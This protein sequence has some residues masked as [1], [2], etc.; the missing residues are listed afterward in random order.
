MKSGL[1]NV[2]CVPLQPDSNSLGGVRL[3]LDQVAYWTER[4]KDAPALTLPS[5]RPRPVE[6]SD[7]GSVYRFDVH[8]GVA[9]RL[10]RLAAGEGATLFE[11]VLSAYLV[12]LYRYTGQTDLLVG[13]ELQQA[14]GPLVNAMIVRTDL[15]GDPTFREL[16]RRVCRVTADAQA[17]G[18]PDVVSAGGPDRGAF[19]AALYV[20]DGGERPRLCAGTVTCDIAL[21]VAAGPSWPGGWA[22]ELAYSTDLFDEP[23]MARMAGHL[24]RI[25]GRAGATPDVRIG[26]IDLLR[27]DERRQVLLDWND[28]QQ[29]RHDTRCMH[30]LFEQQ[31]ARTPDAIAVVFG[32]ERITYRELNVRANQLAWELRRQGVVR[33]ALVGVLMERSADMVAALFAVLKAGG[34]Y[35][36][37]DPAYPAERLRIVLDDCRPWGVVTEAGAGHRLSSYDGH[38]V[39]PRS[40]WAADTALDG[41][42]PGGVTAGDL[43]YLIYTSGSTGKPKGVMIEHRSAVELIAWAQDVFDRQALSCVL[44]STSLCFD[45]SVFEVFVPLSCGGSVLVVQNVL[46]WSESGLAGG[47]TLINTVPSALRELL[48][49][50]RLPSGVRI[51]NVAGEALAAVLVEETFAGADG[52]VAMFNLYGPSEDTTYST[53]ASVE[54]GRLPLIGRPISNTRGY[55]VDTCGMPVPMGVPGEIWIGGAGLARG[56]WDRQA[57]TAERF[58]PDGL[59][60]ASGARLYRT[61]DLGRWTADG[62]MEFLGRLDHQVKIRGHRI[63]LGEVEAALRR[64]EWVE[65]AVVVVREEASGDKRLAAYVVFKAGTEDGAAP[66]LRAYLTE[67]L[68]GYMV[69]SFIVPLAAMP[70]TPNGKVDRRQLP[71]P[72]PMEM[73]R[74]DVALQTPAE[75]LLAGIWQDVLG[76]ARVGAEDDFFELGGHSLLAMRLVS[77]VRDVFGVELPL[78]RLFDEP[79]LHDMARA[80]AE[81]QPVAACAPGDRHARGTVLPLSFGEQRLYFLQ[82]LN[83]EDWKYNMAYAVRLEGE[84]K[85]PALERAIAAMIARHEILRT[86]YVLRRDPERVI[87][88][89]AEYRLI[90]TNAADETAARQLV[91]EESRQPFDMERGPLLRTRLIRITEQ[92][93]VLALTMHHAIA[94]AWSMELWAREIGVLYRS[95]VDGSAPQLDRLPVQY[96]DYAL[97]QRES[98]DSARHREQLAYWTARLADAPTLDLPTVHRRPAIQSQRGALYRFE[99]PEQVTAE[100][101]KVR[102]SEGATLFVAILAAFN[103][104]LHRYTG[105]TDILVGSPISGRNRVELEGV[106]GYFLNTL[107]LRTDLSGNPSFRELLRRVKAVT[108]DAYSRQDVPFEQVVQVLQPERDLSRTPLFSALLVVQHDLPQTWNLPGLDVHCAELDTG[109]SKFDVT[110]QVAERASGWVVE[111]EYCTD[112]FDQPAMERMAAHLG[113]V[114]QQVAA[115]P[116]VRIDEVDLFTEAGANQVVHDWMAIGPPSDDRRG[117]HELFEEQAALTPDAT[118][119][120]FG[121]DSVCYRELNGRAN[122]LARYVRRCTDERA[123]IAVCVDRSIEM[124]VAVLGVLKSGAAYVPIDPGYPEERQQFMLDDARAAVLLTQT[125]RARALDAPHLRTVHLDT[126]WPAVAQES[127]DNLGIPT[128]GDDLLYLIYTSGSTG[129]PKAVALP[130]RALVNLVHWYWSTLSRSVRMLQFASLCFDVATLEIFSA[131]C[132]GGA[133]VMTDEDTRRDISRLAA[134]ISEARV[135]QVFVPV[136]VLDLLAQELCRGDVPVP[137]LR[138]II[139]AGEQLQ[140]TDSARELFERTGGSLHNHYGPSESHVV[141][142]FTLTGA[143]ASWPSQPPIGQPIS[144]TCAFIV[145][146]FGNPV[147]VGVTGEIWIGGVALARCYWERPDLTAE[148]FV[149]DGLSGETGARLY[150]TGDLGRWSADRQIEFLGRLDHQVK[151]RGHRVELGEIEAVLGRH[152]SIAQAIVVVTEETPGDKRLVAYVV[153]KAPAHNDAIATLRTYLER[154]LPEYMSPSLIVPLDHMPLTANGK[155]D[156]TKL[157]APHVPHVPRSIHD[158]AARTPTEERLASLWQDVLGIS[159]V[160]VEEN[161]FKLGGHSLLAMQLA[162]RMHEA[163]HLRVP[164]H[165]IFSHPTIQAC[166]HVIDHRHARQKS[167]TAIEDVGVAVG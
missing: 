163:F 59:S 55:I 158:V 65:S 1:A 114:L 164:L 113:H 81:A 69:P 56:Y 60:G 53:F 3:Q 127:Q 121:G 132:S 66:S 160:G 17:H 32:E 11:T 129:R 39:E 64:H 108:L 43:A 138:E 134:L 85:R 107:V 84:L 150:R 44:A 148:R 76:Y 38:I 82:Q 72:T 104:L 70:L 6:R 83:T 13:T 22:A 48:R 102:K 140:I 105:Q 58:I 159:D 117:I 57:L 28:T 119:V 40:V 47:V 36:P 15:G 79:V 2:P 124:I 130:H 8:S 71:A 92:R 9:D 149:P 87:D 90:V 118:A 54:P 131:L 146:A 144:G 125:T 167:R 96:A 166:A 50:R 41:N 123:P 109:T 12:L 30:E 20:Q 7:A 165:V 136:V 142:S 23:A 93:H 18:L 14:M 21:S 152:A 25:L 77:R 46:E 120:V 49:S 78:R 5:V 137:D 29:P 80:I 95:F 99:I 31:A 128:D 126:D 100:F 97:W 73:G 133:V 88:G 34:A 75:R 68:P 74:R 26:D 67:K 145:D 111:F 103:V 45:L 141:T 35:V 143:P 63:E 155:V 154:T 86:R 52:L 62:E 33:G 61:G 24:V 110:L 51:V 42:L 115:R 156:R 116:D 4:L 157:P 106:F 89:P 151:I 98:T 37:L 91:E 153:W 94:D 27:P 122:Q 162:S 112:L 19:Q 10:R 139:T 147:P 161:F 101:G 135:Q 16:M